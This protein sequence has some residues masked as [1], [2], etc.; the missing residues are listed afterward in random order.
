MLFRSHEAGR[1]RQ[2]F[3]CIGLLGCC[4]FMVPAVL[5][6][7]P[8]LFQV[9]LFAALVCMGAFSSNHWALT[10]RL[11][12]VEAAAKWTGAQNCVGNFSGVVAN[13]LGG[14]TL[15]ATHSFLPAFG[16][17]VLAM[18]ASVAG[19]WFVIRQ[20][21]PVSWQSEPTPKKIRGTGS[22]TIKRA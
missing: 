22:F 17:T 13:Y 7:E 12:G 16:L 4:F 19:Y 2:K 1:V 18:L 6:R 21:A 9:F 11:S 3:I 10:Q 8:V 14:V 5:L 20:P 15:A